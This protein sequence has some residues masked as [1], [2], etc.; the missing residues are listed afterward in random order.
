MYVATISVPLILHLCSYQLATYIH[1]N[2][3]VGYDKV[4]T[5]VGADVNCTNIT[6][7]ALID[8]GYAYYIDD[9]CL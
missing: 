3:I 4:L 7:H 2:F 1:I 8:S 9:K 6:C 5:I